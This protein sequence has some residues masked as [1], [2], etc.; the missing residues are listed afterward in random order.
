MAQLDTASYKA[1]YGNTGTKF[2]DN[3]TELITE[4]IMREQ[5]ENQADSFYN[6]TDDFLVNHFRGAYDASV[7]AYPSSG[8]SGAGG[9][10]QAGNEWYV[11][12][13]GDLD[14]NGLGVTTVY[15]GAILKALVNAP[16]TT[17]SN[18]KVI[19]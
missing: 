8:G 18:W 15:Y 1:L 7:N 3:T 14:I 12:V 5:G 10:I 11:S 4:A 16:G 9:A 19:Q 2:P 6:K 17:P 13:S